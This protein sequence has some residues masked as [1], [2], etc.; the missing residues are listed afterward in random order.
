MGHWTHQHNHGHDGHFDQM[1]GRGYWE[2]VEWVSVGLRACPKPMGEGQGVYGSCTDAPQGNAVA[3][4]M[5]QWH[6]AT[7]GP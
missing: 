2:G 5:V 1:G 3:G 7:Q 4:K 6:S